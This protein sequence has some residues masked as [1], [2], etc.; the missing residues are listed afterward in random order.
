M[1][2]RIIWCVLFAVCWL[3]LIANEPTHGFAVCNLLVQLA[4][5]IP[6]ANIPGLRKNRLSYVDFAWPAGLGAIGIELFFFADKL[7]VLTVS[8]AF[9]YTIVGMRMGI[10]G[11]NMYRPGWLQA[12][13][14]RYQYQRRRWERAGLKSERLSVQY[15]IMVQLMAN[16]SFL[17]VPA[18]LISTNASTT[19]SGWEVT[20]IIAWLGAYL[21]ESIADI[22]KKRFLGGYNETGTGVCDV[23]LWSIS[24]H[25]NYF[26]QWVQWVAMVALAMPSLL[27]LRDDISIIAWVVIGV[28]NLWVIWMMYS[29]MVHYTGAVPAEYYSKLKR[30]EYGDYQTTVNRFFPGPRRVSSL[31]NET[32]GP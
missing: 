9:F 28:A 30:P 27:A 3:T 2:T 23:G 8:A 14:S 22:Q 29:T 4:I 13:L 5:F 1:R 20:A 7:T 26:G 15:E 18:Y 10:W 31:R 24:R 32:S 6:F 21:F 12:E 17:A 11:A 25:P 16:S 19:I